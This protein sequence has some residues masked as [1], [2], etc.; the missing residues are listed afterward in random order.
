MHTLSGRLVASH[1]ASILLI[2]PLVGLILIY[3]METQVVYADLANELI[4]QGRLI[5]ELT[6]Q[7]PD[8]WA[9]ADSAQALAHSETIPS[10]E[11]IMF[12]RPDG[13]LLATNEPLDLAHPGHTLQVN[14]L[15][16]VVGGQTV[17]RTA[18]DNRDLQAEVVEVLI[19]VQ[20]TKH[21]IIGV[22]RLTHGMS[23]VMDVLMRVRYIVAG[24]LFVALL[25]EV[26]IGWGLAVTLQRPL[27]RVTAAVFAL[28]RGG[29]LEPL[30]EQG[31]AEI[32][33]LT[34]G[35]NYLVERL[36][37]LDRMR[38]E[39]RASLVHELRRPLGALH[40]A[41]FALQN[42]AKSDPI[43]SAEL[44]AGM[45]RELE[46][47]ELLVNDLARLHELLLGN[48]ELHLAQTDLNRWLAVVLAPWREVA[49]AKQLNWQENWQHDLGLINM[50]SS[51]LAQALENLINNAIEYTPGGGTI[52]V[53][54]GHDVQTV[55][56]RVSDT[57]PGIPVEE[58][59][60][61]FKPLYQG[62]LGADTKKG[63]GLGLSI[64]RDIVM[65]HGGQLSLNSIPGAGSQFTIILA[66]KM[67]SAPLKLR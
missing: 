22:I 43:L 67:S 57:G 8:F 13:S 40:S 11:R 27:E 32:R 10:R 1:V 3:L 35:V 63:M 21:Q 12:L 34:R 28:T 55:W 49:R 65:A 37:V 4:T 41:T 62:K 15:E 18:Y 24:V 38:R 44:L 30:L 54:A 46:G 33:L 5:A 14:G 20:D 31:P 47:L 50:D 17:E 56:I 36:Q 66:A 26:L 16:S 64:A 52:R 60:A 23:S 58:Q 53:E 42:G 9:S 19:P 59:S 29:R 51:R 48:M 61:V 7:Q 6:R 39:L 2:T 25:A 45:D